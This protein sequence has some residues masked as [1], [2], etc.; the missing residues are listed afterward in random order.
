MI[1]NNSVGLKYFNLK[2][3]SIFNLV[4]AFILMIVI[5]QKAGSYWMLIIEYFF[6]S[7]IDNIN[8]MYRICF[9]IEFIDQ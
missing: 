4:I 9:D 1:F 6:L 7:A 3:N 8:S 5:S 2:N